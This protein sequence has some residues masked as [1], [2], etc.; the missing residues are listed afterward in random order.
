MF[1]VAVAFKSHHHERTHGKQASKQATSTGNNFSVR[2]VMQATVV[3]YSTRVRTRSTLPVC[4]DSP[5]Y[6]QQRLERCFFRAGKSSFWKC[7]EAWPSCVCLLQRTSLC[8]AAGLAKL[9][10]LSLVQ[11][12]M[13]MWLQRAVLLRAHLPMF[14]TAS[15]ARVVVCPL[16]ASTTATRRVTAAKTILPTCRRTFHLA[17]HHALNST[18]G[19]TTDDDGTGGGGNSSDAASCNAVEDCEVSAVI[20][21]EVQNAGGDPKSRERHTVKNGKLLVR[22]RLERLLDRGTD[23]LELSAHAGFQLYSGET[24]SAGGVLTGIGTI[25]GVQ[26]M[27]I[28]NDAT[29]RGGTIYPIG[30]KKQLRAQ[31]VCGW[32]GRKKVGDCVVV[33]VVWFNNGMSRRVCISGRSEFVNACELTCM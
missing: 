15:T 3:A 28:A 7:D 16:L 31:E 32:C 6:H 30:L 22:D 11:K 17:A 26:C 29:V 21:R 27:L 5:F 10:F 18:F 9:R 13:S 33:V 20:D 23:F 4:V 8:A 1:V 24:V 2:V 19:T 12:T 14:S 25:N